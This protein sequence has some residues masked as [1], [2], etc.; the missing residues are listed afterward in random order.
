MF[1]PCDKDDVKMSKFRNIV[2]SLSPSNVG[3]CS[4]ETTHDR[5]T[6]PKTNVCVSNMTWFE[7]RW[8]WF[9]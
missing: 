2:L 7:S 1:I 3:S 8:R 5:S 6:T 9:L 4:S